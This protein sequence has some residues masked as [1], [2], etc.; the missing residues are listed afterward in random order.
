LARGPKRAGARTAALDGDAGQAFFRQRRPRRI[1]EL[2]GREGRTNAFSGKGSTGMPGPS[3]IY[4]QFPL[5]ADA[6]RMRRDDCSRRIDEGESRPSTDG[7]V[8][9]IPVSGWNREAKRATSRLPFPPPGCP[10]VE[11]ALGRSA[12]SGGQECADGRTGVMALF[13]G[14]RFVVESKN[15]GAA[16]AVQ[17]RKAGCARRGGL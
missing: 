17:L 10:G 14:H 15:D 16:E 8:D 5:G 13:P 6:G 3:Q 11:A 9:F 12:V 4:R 7:P 1:E 2:R